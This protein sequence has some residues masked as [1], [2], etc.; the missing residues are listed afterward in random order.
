MTVNELVALLPALP[1]D[2]GECTVYLQ[3]SDA[4]PVAQAMIAVPGA[5][6]DP[7][8]KRVEIRAMLTYRSLVGPAEFS[9]DC[10][11]CSKCGARCDGG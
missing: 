7:A 2:S 1:D 4:L 10:P 6:D 9:G 8:G 11:H 5:A 3:G